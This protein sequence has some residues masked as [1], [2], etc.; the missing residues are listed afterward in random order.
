MR[1]RPRPLRRLAL[2]AVFTQTAFI[3]LHQENVM[4]AFFVL[5]VLFLI[6]FLK[7]MKKPSPLLARVLFKLV[8]KVDHFSKVPQ[9]KKYMLSRE[10]LID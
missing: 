6:F 8:K 10:T 3:P 4:F 1:T 7:S 2:A 5:F 9:H